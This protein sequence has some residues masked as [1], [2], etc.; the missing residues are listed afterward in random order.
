MLVKY[1]R[2]K[3]GRLVGTVVAIGCNAVGVSLCHPR[4]NFNKDMGKKV[5]KGR[6]QLALNGDRERSRPPLPR[7]KDLDTSVIIQEYDRMVD[8]SVRFWRK[9]D[10]I[11][12]SHINISN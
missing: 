1:I 7:R 11:D 8:K 3:Q 12:D 2:N 4:D 5:A 10:D 9:A 6:A